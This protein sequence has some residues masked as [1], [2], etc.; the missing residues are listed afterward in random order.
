MKLILIEMLILMLAFCTNAQVRNEKQVSSFTTASV[1]RKGNPNVLF[2]AID[3][4]NDWTTLF[5]TD[6]PIKTPNLKRLAER[7]TFFTHAY[8]AWLLGVHS[9]AEHYFKRGIY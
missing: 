2:I 7:G 9:L 1:D 6:N 3:D 4:M 8:C 5:D